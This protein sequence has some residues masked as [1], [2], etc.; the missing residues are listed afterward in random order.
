MTCCQRLYSDRFL[1]AQM[2]L[3]MIDNQIFVSP[4]SLFS[5]IVV[6]NEKTEQLEIV[7][8]ITW[9]I[10]LASVFLPCLAL[11]GSIGTNALIVP[12]RALSMVAS[13]TPVVS[14]TPTAVMTISVRGAGQDG[15]WSLVLEAFVCIVAAFRAVATDD[16]TACVMGC[17]SSATIVALV[18]S[19]LCLAL[20]LL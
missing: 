15:G 1:L 20:Q 11:P 6:K 14:A 8:F 3:R 18:E 12:P 17:V 19:L 4:R 10:H 9:F 16:T 2:S 7:V 13:M 5:L